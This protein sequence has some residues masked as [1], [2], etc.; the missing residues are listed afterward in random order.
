MRRIA[1]GTG[2]CV[3]CLA[4]QALADLLPSRPIVLW[5]ERLVVSGEV[6]LTVGSLDRGYFNALD[7]SHDAFNLLTMTVSAELRAHERI[8]VVGEA[9][10]ETALRSREFGPTDRHV[11]R[12]YAFYLRV[13]PLADRP[14]FVQAG[15]VPPVFGAFARAGY[16]AGNPLIGL[17]LAY[18]YPT[19]LRPDTVPPS[20]A[21]LRAN[22]GEGW[23]VRYPAATS[24]T[25]VQGVPLLSARRWDTGIQARWGTAPVELSG[26][27]TNG[28][29][30]KPLTA[31]DNGGK[32]V[33]A[34]VALR[35][36]PAWVVGASV[37]SGE[38]VSDSARAALPVVSRPE[39]YRQRAW[40]IDVEYS[41]GHFLARGELIGSRWH[42][43]FQSGEPAA[44]L[45]AWAGWLEGRLKLTP[46]WSVASRVERLAF[47]HAFGGAGAMTSSSYGAGT[48][49]DWDA[50]VT[51][52]ET[53]ATYLLRRNLRAKASYQHNW[54]DGGR[55][56]R[57]G[58]AAAQLAYWF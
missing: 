10:S 8:A 38:F 41:R 17:P 9:L 56:R 23:L 39:T 34:R 2:A 4:T 35:P 21:E 20:A 55:V 43:P 42:T 31:D 18:H 5:N 32:Q 33:S 19:A 3:L 53:G 49:S 47:S 57:D 26:A 12:P 28:T 6:T 16:G 29:L 54:R 27:V 24:R 36:S 30:S 1:I 44:R 25:G 11:F 52:V 58:L 48:G 22:R 14:F 50:P 15:R 7:Y 37:A 51:R 40:G 13:Q 45:G 46:R